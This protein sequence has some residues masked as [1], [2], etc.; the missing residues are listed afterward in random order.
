MSDKSQKTAASRPHGIVFRKPSRTKQAFK[1]EC[2]V[3]TIMS[4]FEKTALLEHVN[5]YEGRYGDFTGTPQSFHDALNQVVAAREMFMT[6][7]AK[8]RREFDNDPAAFVDFV[9][10]AGE[11][12]LRAKGLLPALQTDER[13]EVPSGTPGVPVGQ[14]QTSPEGSQTP[15]AKS[16]SQ[17]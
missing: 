15:V 9:G 3:N 5:R 17:E 2:D 1:D 14:P 8:V 6:L 16:A 11:D 10:T 4:R 12:E 13:S 7:P